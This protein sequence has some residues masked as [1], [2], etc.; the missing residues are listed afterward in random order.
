MK[1][2]PKTLIAALLLVGG[3]GVFV[4]T[5][6][7]ATIAPENEPEAAIQPV[8][9]QVAVGGDLPVRLRIPRLNLDAHIQY[10]GIAK[11]GAMAVPSNFTDVAWYKAGTVPG[12]V[13]S[14]VMDGHVDNGLALPGVFKH[15]SDIAVGDEIDV[16]TASSSVRR[17]VVSE[18]ATYPYQAVPTELLFNR[19]DQARLNLITCEGVWIAGQKTYDERLVVYGVIKS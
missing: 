17:F 10:V 4:Y 3:V 19:A 9:K 8:S 12:F 18:I 2:S 7:R 5:L 14:A 1:T 11:S 15:L 6:A 16:V 13:G